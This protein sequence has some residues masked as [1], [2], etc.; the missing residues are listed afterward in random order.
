MNTGFVEAMKPSGRRVVATRAFIV[1]GVLAFLLAGRTL[2]PGAPQPPSRPAQGPPIPGTDDAEMIR[3][4][5]GQFSMGTRESEI[6]QLVTA[7]KKGGTEHYECE[8]RYDAEG[9]R[10]PVKVGDFSLD[11]T[12]VTNAQFEAFVRSTGHISSAESQ[13]RSDVFRDVGGKW[14][15]E[16]QAGLAW[17]R[18]SGTGTTALPPHPVVHVSWTDAAAYCQWAGKRLP[19]EAEWEYAARGSAGRRYPWGEQWGSGHAR[20]FDN[21]GEGTSA[22]VGSYPSGASPFGVLDLA[23]NVWE[24]TSSL[25]RPYPYDPL[26]GREEGAAVGK[27]AVRGGGWNGYGV[28]LRATR[29]AGN[30]ASERSNVLGFRCAR[31][32]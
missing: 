13:G 22:P 6:D 26:D 23:G 27:R 5:T 24:W 2:L 9:P 12:E 3:I 28:S 30:S 17:R 18:P 16:T 31:T 21:R 25:F 14:A 19:T 7:C 10:H 1:V 8:D 11:K 20:H 29:R 4:P 32:P 15:W